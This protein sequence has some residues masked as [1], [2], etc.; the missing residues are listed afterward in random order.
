M[1]LSV[2][3]IL[4]AKPPGPPSPSDDPGRDPTEQ[5]DPGQPSS[6]TIPE[7]SPLTGLDRELS[8]RNLP[9]QTHLQSPRL[10]GPSGPSADPPAPLNLAL[11]DMGGPSGAALPPSQYPLFTQRPNPVASAFRAPAEE[12]EQSPSSSP[13][14]PL[15]AHSLDPA[16]VRLTRST[17]AGSSGGAAY[18]DGGG[19]RRSTRAA[20][21]VLPAAAP[22][23]VKLEF[24]PG[25]TPQT[26]GVPLL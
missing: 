16:L 17:R 4:A 20:S 18:L 11:V 24:K 25:A 13:S 2:L 7:A 19:G 5:P 1:A 26:S 14:A 6:S 8:V 15:R 3:D 9:E 21:A 23:P 10:D 12:E 22:P